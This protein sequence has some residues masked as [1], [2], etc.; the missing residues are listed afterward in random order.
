MN[1]PLIALF[2][3]GFCLVQSSQSAEIAGKSLKEF[4]A[5]G[6]VVDIACF[7]GKNQKRNHLKCTKSCLLDGTPIGLL[8]LDGSLYLLLEDPK[9]SQFFRDLKQSPSEKVR[10]KGTVARRNGIQTLSVSHFERLQESVGSCSE[11]SKET[12]AM[13]NSSYC[14]EPILKP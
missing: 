1:K 6:E 5:E 2:L 7:M 10:V 14:G 12:N 11:P 8:G 13:P 3:T 9:A 4:S